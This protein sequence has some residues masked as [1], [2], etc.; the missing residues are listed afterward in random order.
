MLL[1]KR[2]KFKLDSYDED[3]YRIYD[4]LQRVKFNKIPSF[5]MLKEHLTPQPGECILD[6]GCGAGHLLDYILHGTTAKGLGIDSS[7]TALSLAGRR[8]PNQ[9]YVLQ[10]LT[11]VGIQSESIDKI[12]CFNVIEHIG[13]QENVMAEFDRILKPGGL[14]VIGTNIKNSLAWKL[15]QLFIGDHTHIREF[16]VPEFIQF[17]DRFFDV[18]HYQKS[19]GVFRLG[20][21]L[22]WIF[23]Y[24]L[25]GDIIAAC[26]KKGRPTP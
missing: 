15:Y 3:Y 14:L 4:R 23:H 22:S 13:P 5:K 25:L 16:S 19:S 12:V 6:A 24:I 2:S 7:E 10:D 18:I 20:P 1:M 17:V 26:R 8:F 9:P 11:A 21:S